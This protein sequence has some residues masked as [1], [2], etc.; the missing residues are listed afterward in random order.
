MRRDLFPVE[1]CD[2]LST[3]QDRATGFPGAEAI[4][5]LEEE[6]GAPHELVFSMFEERPIAAGSIGQVHRAQLKDGSLVAVKGQRRGI[7]AAFAA[8]MRWLERIVRVINALGI[9]PEA[10][11]SEFR[12]ELEQM[13]ANEL[14]Y[15]SEAAAQSAMRSKLLEHRVYVPRVFWEL[16]SRRV[17]VMEFISGVMMT[18]FIEAWETDR[19]RLDAWLAENDVEPQRVGY[20][21][22][23][24]H[25]R[26]VFEDNLFHGDLH[27]GNIVL[28][29]GSQIAL[30]D[31]GSV[32]SIDTNRLRKYYLLFQSIASGA[33]EKAADMLI[34]LSPEPPAS[35]REAIASEITRQ[36]KTWRE[37][38][39]IKSLP[40]H[41][42]SLT[43]L[44]TGLML[45]LKRH[46]VP[47]TWE[48]M[49]VNRA[50]VTM[51]ASLAYLLPHID[52]FR[53]I[54]TYE[55]AA[56]QRELD[57]ALG[58]DQAMQWVQR[59]LQVAEIFDGAGE[60]AYFETEWVRERAIQ[61][62]ASVTKAGFGV[63][64]I[65]GLIV[66]LSSAIIVGLIFL[67]AYQR[68]FLRSTAAWLEIT[69]LLDPVPRLSIAALVAG[70]AVL[71]YLRF[72]LKKAS[73][74]SK[75]YDR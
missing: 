31:F 75:G 19:E 53:M 60:R 6:L 2:V 54:R 26:Q 70:V 67:F 16:T 21:L 63:A 24:T 14:D 69:N 25:T 37:R 30:I 8:D 7:E 15:R 55:R 47:A 23:D 27:P 36:L 62:S 33:F 28:L 29:R 13:F 9:R 41:E 52:Y 4:L 17:L 49:R 73:R 43:T 65:V 18:E 50:E 46:R 12:W 20:Y 59:A 39:R 42:K 5:I 58:H 48:F 38:S 72:E 74:P 34:L 22:Y 66:P 56:R 10:R 71:L 57:R 40:Y 45:A 35:A 68:G 32:G 64:A 3:L 11:W 44:M 1:L 51:D 61:L